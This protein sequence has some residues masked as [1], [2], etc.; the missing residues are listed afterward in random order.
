MSKVREL[1]Q[2]FIDLFRV[3]RLIF[4]LAR[5]DF[6][7]KYAGNYF[8][9]VWA[10]LQ[11]TISILIFW[12]IF[13]VGFK[14]TPIDNFPFILW[15]CGAMI[16]WFFFS[17]GLQTATYS[18]SENSYL[19]KKVV[20]R[21]S[22]LPL[23]KIISAFFVHLFFIVFLIAMFA[24]YGYYPDVYDFQL[25][26]YLFALFVL[27]MSLSWIT[28]TLV[29]FLKDVGQIVAMLI[30]FGF[31]L[32][33]I[34]YSLETVPQKFHFLYTFNPVYY[35]TKGYRDSLIY[36]R[37]FWQDMQQTCVFWLITAVLM[38]IGIVLF[39]KLKPH[40]ADVI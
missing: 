35:I 6:R 31:W 4:D 32:T 3:R 16:P 11:P 7:S 28:S 34:F 36:H 17:D 19:V 9:I 13:Q 14:S 26:Y 27:L 30:Q 15:L 20:F 25:I 33:P 23:I 5:K 24:L 12:F 2:F 18:I 37:W 29:I 10:F 39:K 1:C 38:L 22:M 40:F 8:G 21:V